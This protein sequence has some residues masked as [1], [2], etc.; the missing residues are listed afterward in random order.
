[1]EL[2]TRPHAQPLARNLHRRAANV[3]KVIQKQCH[4]GLLSG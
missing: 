3:Q 1:M 4:Y 2:V